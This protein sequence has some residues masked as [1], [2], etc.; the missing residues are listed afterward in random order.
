[1]RSLL[2]EGWFAPTVLERV[3]QSGLKQHWTRPMDALP[4]AWGQALS[5]VFPQN[6]AF[7]WATLTISPLIHV[8]SAMALVAMLRRRLSVDSLHV[9]ALAFAMTPTI[10]FQLSPGRLDHHGL[11][12]AVLLLMMATAVAPVLN[13]GKGRVA[14]LAFGALAAL[15]AWAS[16][17]GILPAAAGLGAWGLLWCAAGDQYAKAGTLAACSALGLA[18]V[19]LPLERGLGSSTWTTVT[20]DRFSIFHAACF[21]MLAIGLAGALVLDRV[22][23]QRLAFRWSYALLGLGLVVGVVLFLAPHLSIG[24]SAWGDPFYLSVRGGYVRRLQ[25]LWQASFERALFH[26]GMFGLGALAAI[27]TLLIW[28]R[29]WAWPVFA[30]AVP[31]T[32]ALFYLRRGGGLIDRNLPMMTAPLLIGYSAVCGD[33]ITLLRARLPRMGAAAAAMTKGVAGSCVFLVLFFLPGAD[34]SQKAGSPRAAMSEPV[35]KT[36]QQLVDEKGRRTRVLAVPEVNVRLLASKELRVLAIGNHRHQ[37]GFQRMY[38]IFSQRRP[39]K[40]AAL[41]RGGEIDAAVVCGGSA[42]YLRRGSDAPTTLYQRMAEGERL[43][44]FSKMTEPGSPCGVY[45]VQE[46]DATRSAPP[47]PGGGASGH[48][49]E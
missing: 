1:M 20:T 31:V 17:A 9:L 39:E 15:L 25:S 27:A 49:A 43:P 47:R 48:R 34:T 44:G 46:Q 22:K 29:R 16:P 41:M 14:P 19:F 37:P 7:Q 30:L 32:F 23:I 18:V 11:A 3:G 13:G 24:M 6:K 28:R 35:Q 26:A 45:R 8:V 33:A 5:L 42:P 40:A 10:F 2:E 21:A 36:L 12:A 4:A 38:A